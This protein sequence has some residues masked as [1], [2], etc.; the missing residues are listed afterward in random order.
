M[1]PIET[2]KP[3]SG[4]R[5]ADQV[6]CLPA[7]TLGSKPHGLSCGCHA[8]LWIF[9]Q[10]CLTVLTRTSSGVASRRSHRFRNQL[11]GEFENVALSVLAGPGNAD[12]RGSARLEPRSALREPRL[13]RRLGQ[14]QGRDTV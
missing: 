7:R 9:E 1:D 6:L 8:G 3:H 4:Y 5:I 11:L 2:F 13:T 12:G 14:F 10:S